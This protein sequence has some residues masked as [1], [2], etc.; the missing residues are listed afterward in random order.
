M[1]KSGF[2]AAEER[3]QRLAEALVYSV[4]TL[5]AARSR[6][7][8]EKAA[9]GAAAALECKLLHGGD[10]ATIADRLS[11]LGAVQEALVSSGSIF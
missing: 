1:L 9:L 10:V 7:G 6:E 11:A 5:L 2:V 8:C 3:D 4:A